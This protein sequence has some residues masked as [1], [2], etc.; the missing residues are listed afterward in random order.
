VRHAL[1][2]ALLALAGVALAATPQAGQRLLAD[3]HKA[4]GVACTAC[5]AEAPP[6]K[7]VPTA[8]C[9]GCHGDFKALA[10]K[11]EHAEPNPHQS[12]QGEQDCAECHH[13]HKRSD[14]NCAR[15]HVTN[16]RVP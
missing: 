14:D 13:V 2:V 6:A 11:T 5:H 3:A 9:R 8:Q 1:A 10:R 12:H 16:W 7:A 4:K 15:C